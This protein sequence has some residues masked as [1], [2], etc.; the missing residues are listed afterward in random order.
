MNNNDCDMSAMM[1][2]YNIICFHMNRVQY[3]LG[4]LFR[5]LIQYI[6]DQNNSIALCNTD[7]TVN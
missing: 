5:E 2:K 3:R 6:E 4:K 7:L 1:A